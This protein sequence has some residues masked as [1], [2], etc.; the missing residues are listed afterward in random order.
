MHIFKLVALGFWFYCAEACDS[1]CSRNYRPVC[2]FDGT[3]YTEARNPCFMKSINCSR[4]AN[5]KPVFKNIRN[6]ACQKSVTICH[7]GSADN[8]Q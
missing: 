4:A 7:P 6:G 3:C 1:Y 5:K 2:G 8:D